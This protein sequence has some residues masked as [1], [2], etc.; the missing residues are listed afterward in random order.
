MWKGDSNIGQVQQ[1]IISYDCEPI[2]TEHDKS[3]FTACDKHSRNFT[4]C[5]LVMM[6]W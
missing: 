4:D 5:V 3:E 6:Q 2:R 1:E